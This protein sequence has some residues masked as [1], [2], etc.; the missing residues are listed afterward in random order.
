M[1]IPHVLGDRVLVLEVSSADFA[2]NADRSFLVLS[3]VRLHALLEEPAIAH[4]AFDAF[5]PL[6]AMRYLHVS[7]K[8]DFPH[9]LQADRAGFCL[10]LALFR[11]HVR[12]VL[13]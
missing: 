2:V 13:L 9:G 8:V 6:L 10:V 11:V 7:W 3:H 12:H 4:R 1:K 5:W